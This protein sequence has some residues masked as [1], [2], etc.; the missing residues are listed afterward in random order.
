MHLQVCRAPRVRV[1]SSGGC[2]MSEF[3]CTNG[4]AQ[5]GCCSLGMAS[6]GT[7]KRLSLALT[8]RREQIDKLKYKCGSGIPELQFVF[9][10]DWCPMSYAQDRAIFPSAGAQTSGSTNYL[11]YRKKE[12]GTW[13]VPLGRCLP[14][15]QVIIPGSWAPGRQQ[16]PSAIPPPPRPCSCSLSYSFFQINKI[17]KKIFRIEK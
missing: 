13:G 2:V 1:L 15:A 6:P 9:I 4:V 14:S 11:E 5:G 17:L 8:L 12:R 3:P 16:A 10:T 7:W